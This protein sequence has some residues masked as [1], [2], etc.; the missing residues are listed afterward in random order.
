MSGV[1]GYHRNLRALNK[2]LKKVSEVVAIRVARRCAGALN[3]VV[4]ASFDSSQTVYDDHRPLGKRGNELTLVKSGSVRGAIGFVS[5][6]TSK[7][8][9]VLAQRYAKYLVGKYRILPIG[10]ATIPFKWQVILRL[11]INSEMR[12]ILEEGGSDQ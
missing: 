2:E 1:I 6:G 8:R 3:Y 12:K 10:G 5:D 11:N 9:A 7:I 4:R